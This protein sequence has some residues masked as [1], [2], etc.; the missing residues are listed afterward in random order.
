M[1]GFS[2]SFNTLKNIVYLSDCS[3][4]SATSLFKSRSRLLAGWLIISMKDSRPTPPFP[5]SLLK[6]LMPITM[7]ESSQSYATFSGVVRDTNGLRPALGS[8]DSSAAAT[9]LSMV[10]EIEALSFIDE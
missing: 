2:N 10:F 4:I 6:S 7:F 3:M 8:T 1:P 9:S 5:I